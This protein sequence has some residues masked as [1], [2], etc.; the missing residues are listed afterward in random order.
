M[1]IVIVIQCFINILLAYEPLRYRIVGNSVGIEFTPNSHLQ[2]DEPRWVTINDP[3][4]PN[5]FPQCQ[6]LRQHN[7][8]EED[9]P[10][11]IGNWA[12]QEERQ[13]NM[14]AAANGTPRSDGYQYPR[15]Y[16]IK[17]R[18]RDRR[19]QVV[20]LLNPEAPNIGW[21]RDRFQTQLLALIC[22]NGII[23]NFRPDSRVWGHQAEFDI[24]YLRPGSCG[25]EVQLIKVCLLDR[26]IPPFTDIDSLFTQEMYGGYPQ[27]TEDHEAVARQLASTCP[28]L[29]MIMLPTTVGG[30]LNAQGLTAHQTIEFDRYLRAAHEVIFD[31]ILVMGIGIS[32]PNNRFVRNRRLEWGSF[33]LAQVM[34]DRNL[35]NNL[36]RRTTAPRLRQYW[37]FC[38][39]R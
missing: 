20:A 36:L 23:E 29:F 6:L 7:W 12:T 22:N 39:T 25:F 5:R 11:I 9:H 19:I 16:I 14:Q 31:R 8:D 37:L 30:N 24:P 1:L 15:Y 21:N 28:R 27:P 35:K 10:Q 18:T 2:F 32:C 3:R 4:R 33:E 34:N 26:A 38:K 13:E 17:R